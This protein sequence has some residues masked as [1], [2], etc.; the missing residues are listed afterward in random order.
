MIYDYW[1]VQERCYLVY[2]YAKNASADLT[3]EQLRRLADLMET[4]LNRES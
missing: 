1:V 3:K 4:E 2:A